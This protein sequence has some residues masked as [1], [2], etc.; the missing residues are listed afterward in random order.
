MGENRSWYSFS[1]VC[2]FFFVFFFFFLTGSPAFCNSSVFL[3]SHLISSLND[4]LAERAPMMPVLDVGSSYWALG[5]GTADLNHL[6]CVSAE[7][8]TPL[9]TPNL[10]FGR[11]QPQVPLCWCRCWILAAAFKRCYAAGWDCEQF[12]LHW[13]RW[14]RQT[15]A[16]AAAVKVHFAPLS[17]NFIST[18]DINHRGS[19]RGANVLMH[20]SSQL[21]REDR[22]EEGLRGRNPHVSSVLLKHLLLRPHQADRQRMK[23]NRTSIIQIAG[24][25]CFGL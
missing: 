24:L 21:R 9:S 14:Y 19:L 18:F 25:I 8:Q 20:F 7:V 17:G 11:K 2:W 12:R 6:G 4:P 15:G 5:G 22:G 13:E 3:T 16:K 10:H 23:A 1:S